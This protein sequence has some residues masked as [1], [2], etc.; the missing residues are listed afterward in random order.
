MDYIY[1]T[2]KEPAWGWVGALLEARKFA[3]PVRTKPVAKPKRDL[4]PGR[5]AC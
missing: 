4:R 3:V 2:H 5:A 1:S